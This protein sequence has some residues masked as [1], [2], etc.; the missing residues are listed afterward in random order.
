LS[1]PE[2]KLVSSSVGGTQESSITGIS[3][4]NTATLMVLMKPLDERERSTQQ[5]MN[6]FQERTKGIPGVTITVNTDAGAAG[7]SGLQVN[8]SGQDP[9]VLEELNNQVSEVLANIP[10]VAS[11]ES[12]MDA[13][14]PEVAIYLDRQAAALY[15]ITPM[16][17]QTAVETAFGGKKVTLVRDGKD[18]LDVRL[19][20]PQ[21]IQ[22]EYANLENLTLRSSTGALLSLGDVATVVTEGAPI[23][24]SRS[25][26]QRQVRLTVELSGERPLG[27]VMAQVTQEL[28]GM[29]FPQGYEWNLG[30]E[31]EQMA[32]SFQ[33]LVLAMILAI[34]LVYM[35]MAAQFES[36]F[37]PFVIMFCLPPTFV[38]AFLGLFVH[39]MPISVT[40]LIGLLMLI[41]IV[42]NNAI[43][44]VDYTNQLRQA[45]Y[46]RDEALLMA[47]PVRLRP[48]LMTMLSTNL[49]L[50]PFAYF[51][52]ESSET[53]RPLA[54][55][56]IYGLLVSTLITLLL[57]PAVYSL[58]DGFF[59]RLRRRFSRKKGTDVQ[60]EQKE[61]VDAAERQVAASEEEHAGLRHADSEKDRSDQ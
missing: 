61:L 19:M 18:E 10:G 30:G 21:D 57:V 4:S 40:A 59:T 13:A 51:G 5:V 9:E 48:I 41:G 28:Q 43:V 47:G 20:L 34:A 27:E 35:I 2:V 8:I 36:F 11:V 23:S 56:V 44:L 53:M 55:V 37:Q 54:I 16:E 29:S 1:F 46:G 6:E 15:G 22:Q 26:G 39:G 12:S 58:S 38:G 31:A 42:M 60:L 14:R 50:V 7:G 49:V 52:G 25:E 45:G 17:I 24:I 33:S 3:T 32:E